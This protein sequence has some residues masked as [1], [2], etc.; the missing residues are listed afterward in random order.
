MLDW[1]KSFANERGLKW[2]QDAVGN[3]VVYR[4]Q[5]CGGGEAAPP[6]VI[7]VPLGANN[8]RS[9]YACSRCLR[10]YAS[11]HWTV[12]QVLLLRLSGS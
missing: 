1:V 6:V 3:L 4:A 8:F 12:L 2:R 7:Q 9:F 5:A 10:A 11:F